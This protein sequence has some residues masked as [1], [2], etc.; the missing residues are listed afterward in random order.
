MER[1]PRDMSVLQRISKKA[2]MLLRVEL[3]HALLGKRV[4]W[5]QPRPCEGAGSAFN[6]CE[7]AALSNLRK[8]SGLSGYG[9]RNGLNP[10]IV[11]L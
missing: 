3:T 10:D 5:S 8:I 7:Y 11:G 2:V 4:A 9:F 1:E 6:P